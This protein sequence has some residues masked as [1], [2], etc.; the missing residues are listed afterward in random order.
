MT[1][2]RS[3]SRAHL[4]SSCGDRQLD[5]AASSVGGPE[6][7]TRTEEEGM[8]CAACTAGTSAEFLGM[9]WGLPEPLLE[10]WRAALASVTR[11]SDITV[12]FLFKG[13]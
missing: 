2:W 10:A 12:V 13:I 9:A 7:K 4:G 1:S 6:E 8:A 5:L 3:G 11:V